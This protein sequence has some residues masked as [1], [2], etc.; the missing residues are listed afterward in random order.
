MLELQNV[1]GCIPFAIKIGLYWDI[2]A[3]AEKPNDKRTKSGKYIKRG[4]ING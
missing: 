1:N 4:D 2:P 3:D